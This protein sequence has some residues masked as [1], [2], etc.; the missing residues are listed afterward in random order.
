MGLRCRVFNR[1]ADGHHHPT[2]ASETRSVPPPIRVLN[3][4]VSE[5]YYREANLTSSRPQRVFWPVSKA[6]G[7]IHEAGLTSSHSHVFWPASEANVIIR[8]AVLTI[9]RLQHVIWPDNEVNVI[10]REEKEMNSFVSLTSYRKLTF[11]R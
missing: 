2:V 5:R 3:G 10:I 7:M 4:S 9:S 1:V 11:Y 6:N 8:E